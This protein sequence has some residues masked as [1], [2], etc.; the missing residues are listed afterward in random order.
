[1]SPSNPAPWDPYLTSSE[2]GYRVLSHKLASWIE[3][4]ETYLKEFAFIFNYKDEMPVQQLSK[5]KLVKI[6]PVCCC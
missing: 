2:G 3:F 5:E 1:M 6:L 4:I